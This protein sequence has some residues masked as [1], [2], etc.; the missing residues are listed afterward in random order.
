MYLNSFSRPRKKKVNLG[1]K[2]PKVFD[3]K[4]ALKVLFFSHF[5]FLF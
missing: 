4:D 3:R 1:Q 5:H 2:N